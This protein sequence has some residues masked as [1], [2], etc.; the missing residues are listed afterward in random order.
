MGIVRSRIRRSKDLRLLTPE[1][2]ISLGFG[3]QGECA[4]QGG[5]RID[6]IENRTNELLDDGNVAQQA[7]SRIEDLNPCLC[8]ARPKESRKSF[9]GRV[10][11]ELGREL[12]HSVR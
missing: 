6:A 8:K 10:S 7:A 5:I 9:P 11:P 1:I 4:L 2:Q 3:P 12:I